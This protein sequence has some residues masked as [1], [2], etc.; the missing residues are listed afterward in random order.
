M[1]FQGQLKIL[2]YFISFVGICRG[3]AVDTISKWGDG[4]CVNPAQTPMS[5]IL[6][7]SDL[8][9]EN[10]VNDANTT[11]WYAPLLSTYE[12]YKTAAMLLDISIDDVTED[13]IKRSCI[14][15][16]EE[17]GKYIQRG[18]KDKKFEIVGE[19]GKHGGFLWKIKGDT[20]YRGESW[21]VLTTSDYLLSVTC[22][23]NG[24]RSFSAVSKKKTLDEKA[25]KVV[26]DKVISLG[27]NPKYFYDYDY[28][29]CNMRETF[30]AAMFENLKKLFKN[31][32]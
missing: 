30:L 22:W 17:D 12:L 31:L 21:V 2:V 27:F 7:N 18:F 3:A 9:S 26:T 15:M 11:I 19:P 5:L 14:I 10:E 16:S 8:S 13:D 25:R 4:P 6:D 29:H 32:A 1:L 28:D 20:S 23:A 24:H